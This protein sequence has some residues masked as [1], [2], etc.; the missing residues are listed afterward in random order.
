[1]DDGRYHKT[2][3]GNI[4]VGDSRKNIGKMADGSGKNVPIGG[5]MARNSRLMPEKDSGQ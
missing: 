5:R 1:M 2:N 4:C 3:A